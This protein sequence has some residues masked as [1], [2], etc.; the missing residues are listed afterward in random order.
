[1]SNCSKCNKSLGWLN[2]AP[3]CCDAEGCTKQFCD[4]CKQAVKLCDCGNSYCEEHEA[5]EKHDCG[6]EIFEEPGNDVIYSPEK[7]Y[8]KVNI[9]LDVDMLEKLDAEGYR[10][11]YC[12]SLY[13]E[14]YALM[15]KKEEAFVTEPKELV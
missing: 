13:E 15:R 11:I 9:T 3:I 6:T 10:V 7:K 14:F 8:A 12:Y 1:M 2:L 4:D 5:K